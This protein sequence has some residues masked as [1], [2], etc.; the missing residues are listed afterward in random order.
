MIELYTAEHRIDTFPA[1]SPWGD[2]ITALTL[3]TRCSNQH[4]AS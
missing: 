4:P 3:Y 1:N 2:A